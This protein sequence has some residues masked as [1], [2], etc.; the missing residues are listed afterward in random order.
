MEQEMIRKVIQ[1]LEL[2][3]EDVLLLPFNKTA[4]VQEWPKI[5]RRFVSFKTENGKTRI[6]LYDEV[7][8]ERA[9]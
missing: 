7:H 5:G 3:K 8:V 1:G 2:R 4:T 6:G 9:S